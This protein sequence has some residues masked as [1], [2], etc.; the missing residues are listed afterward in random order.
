M[1]PKPTLRVEGEDPRVDARYEYS[2]LQRVWVAELVS[3]ML[4]D[5]RMKI[6]PSRSIYN[7]DTSDKLE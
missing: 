4:K 3:R 5:E 7:Q 1:T 2:A 6:D